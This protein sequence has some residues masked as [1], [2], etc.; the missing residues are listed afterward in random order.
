MTSR[1]ISAQIGCM[2]D[3]LEGRYVAIVV[4]LPGPTS[5]LLGQVYRDK[6]G[7]WKIAYRFRYYADDQVFDS[8]DVKRGYRFDLAPH[9]D[10]ACAVEVILSLCRE[11]ISDGYDGARMSV[12]EVRSDK[13]DVF[14]KA[15]E[16]RPWFH[17]RIE[18]AAEA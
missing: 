4:M 12:V 13:V 2:P 14:L 8:E 18:G 1:E 3:V 9:V 5:D 7:P 16:A 15:M 17:G 11:L 10:E 6:D